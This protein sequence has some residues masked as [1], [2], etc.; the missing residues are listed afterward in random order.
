MKK[1]TDNQNFNRTS[2]EVTSTYEL[3]KYLNSPFGVVRLTFFVCVCVGAREH[4]Y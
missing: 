2:R 1:L 4:S 3:H